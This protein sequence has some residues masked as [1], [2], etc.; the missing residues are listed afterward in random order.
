MDESPPVPDALYGDETVVF[1]EVQIPTPEEPLPE[2]SVNNVNGPA[3]ASAA[4][5]FQPSSILFTSADLRDADSPGEELI[6]KPEFGL[7]PPP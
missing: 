7:V 5:I 3:G 4:L 2:Y 1:P 6:V